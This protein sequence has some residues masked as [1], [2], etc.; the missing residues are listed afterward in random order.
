[1]HPYLAF[2]YIRKGEGSI[3]VPYEDEGGPT[4]PPFPS[5]IVEK[6]LEFS[7]GVKYTFRNLFHCAGDIGRR[8]IDNY[9]HVEGDNRN[10]TFFSIGL[11]VIL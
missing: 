10:D 2:R 1:M 6:K 7:A 9:G 3:F 4:N 11:W 8:N 5:G